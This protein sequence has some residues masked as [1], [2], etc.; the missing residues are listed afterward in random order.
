MI[1]ERSS[2]SPIELR[3]RLCQVVLDNRISSIE[4]LSELTGMEEDEARIA[5]QEL[6]SEGS[7]AGKFTEDGT[8]F[9]LSDVKVSDAPILG[10]ADTGPDIVIKESKV[11]KTVVITG[12]IL[13]VIGL[14]LRG[15]TILG[16]FMEVAGGAVFV[17]GLVLFFIGWMMFS[18]LNPPSQKR[19]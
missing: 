13:T 6:V 15:I 9:F 16:E 8:R 2:T 19:P 3:T 5:L 7:L 10:P 17:V 18:R 14:I 11:P 12:I 4:R 1:I